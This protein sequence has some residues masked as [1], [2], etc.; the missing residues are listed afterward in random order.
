MDTLD[1]NADVGE[2]GPD[3]AS[4][5][6]AGISSANVSCAAHAGDARTLAAACALA[7]TH[8]V[9]LGAHPGFADPEAFGRREH[10]LTPV[11]LRLL[12]AHQW[13]ALLAPATA[14]GLRIQ[15]VKPHGALYHQL[16]R[17]PTLAHAFI[18]EVANTFPGA[19]IFGPPAGALANAAAHA[20]LSFVP[21][22]FI[23]R[24]YGPD[25]RL[26]PR[27]HPEA[28]LHEPDEAVA[29][30]LRLARTGHIRTLCAH[31]DGAHSLRLLRAVRAA[32][33]AEGFGIEAPKIASNSGSD[34]A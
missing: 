21:E 26:L 17:D 15:H 32:L 2:G 22:G 24:R 11:S 25:G 7:R 10:P 18:A 8:H 19:A 14:L 34:K 31:G 4:L 28:L 30:A 13:A 9:A 12:L 27:T 16:D 20:G 29:Q 33:L 3:D 1:L 5:F 23:D 6:A